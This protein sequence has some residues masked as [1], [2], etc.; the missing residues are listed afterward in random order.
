MFNPNASE[1][2]IQAAL[3]KSQSLEFINRLPDGIDTLM[4]N[5]GER[6]SGGE[7]QRIALAR[8]LVSNPSVLILD[9]A[10]SALDDDNERGILETIKTLRNSITIVIIAHR[11]STVESADF[12]I[13]VK[14]GGS[15]NIIEN[16]R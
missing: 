5:K 12:V 9:E 8:A 6:L 14:D 2:D 3:K 1:I 13:N 16:N 15:V 4:G 11:H 7:K 10:T